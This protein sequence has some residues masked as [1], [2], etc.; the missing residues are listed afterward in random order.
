MTDRPMQEK[1]PTLWRTAK[2][3]PSPRKGTGGGLRTKGSDIRINTEDPLRSRT[4]L[5]IVDRLIAV[6]NGARR[7][8]LP[9]QAE[10]LDDLK[11]EM[12]ALREVPRP[13]RDEAAAALIH[14]AH[15]VENDLFRLARTQPS[16]G[17]VATALEVEGL[18]EQFR[19]LFQRI[20]GEFR[21]RG[22][23]PKPWPLEKLPAEKFAPL[24]IKRR[25]A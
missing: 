2:G 3:Q 13:E 22:G 5:K 23:T 12:Y 21:R 16:V 7:R 11:R 10:M 25:M 20:T 17:A 4:F 14:Q 24:A 1:H 19:H 9:E 6:A 15:F 18:E 8:G